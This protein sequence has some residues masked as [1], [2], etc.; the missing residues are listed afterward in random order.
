MGLL[1]KK[2]KEFILDWLNVVEGKMDRLE[3]YKKWSSKKDNSTFFEDYK[4]IGT[5]MS[6]DE[7][8]SK[9]CKKAE[10]KNRIRVMK[11]KI[12]KKFE[13]GKKDLLL[14]KSFL[15]LEDLP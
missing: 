12:K 1:T 6:I 5:K 7:F 13:E 14:I 11:H 3:F 10:W 9:W 2:E 8:K 4:N 15:E